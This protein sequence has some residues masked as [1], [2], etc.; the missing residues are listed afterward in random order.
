MEPISG[1]QEHMFCILR[2]YCQTVNYFKTR[3]PPGAGLLAHPGEEATGNIIVLSA[4]RCTLLQATEELGLCKMYC[5]GD[6][7]AFAYDDRDNFRDSGR[8]LG[9]TAQVPLCICF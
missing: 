1:F 6:M 9:A 7:E 8:A 4:P 3:F 2:I 5:S